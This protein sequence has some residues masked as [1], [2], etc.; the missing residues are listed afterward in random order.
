MAA[1]TVWALLQ[2]GEAPAPEEAVRKAYEQVTDP[3]AR[4]EKV[5]TPDTRG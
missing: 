2:P 5:P 4:K 3:T 1:D